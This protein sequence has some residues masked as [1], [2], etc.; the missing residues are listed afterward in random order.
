MNDLL[1]RVDASKAALDA[2]RPLEE[3]LLSQIRDYYRVGL[4]WSS[5]ALEGNS[6]TETETKVILEDG[7]TIGGKPLREVYEATGHAQAYDYMFTI[8]RGHSITLEDMKTLH[9]LFYKSIDED[10]AG[11]WRKQRIIVTGSEYAFPGPGRVEAEMKALEDWVLHDRKS[12]HPVEFAALLHAKFV[13]VHPFVDG[14]GRTARLLMNLALLQDGYTPALVP[15]VLRAD[16]LNA[17]RRFQ[18]KQD[19]AAFCDFVAEQVLQ[20]QKDLLRLL[21]E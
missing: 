9:R 19:S 16:Y 15:P 1:A 7:L 14:N 20:T 12:L 10:N 4:T 8:V 21:G 17:I 18:M 6:L 13:T 11:Q 3:P 5:N 2:F